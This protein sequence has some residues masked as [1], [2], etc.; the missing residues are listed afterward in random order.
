MEASEMGKNSKMTPDSAPHPWFCTT[1]S[2]KALAYALSL[3][4]I[5]ETVIFWCTKSLIQPF[6]SK[7]RYESRN[8][9]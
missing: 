4:D 5:G 9:Y 1:F 6:V 3:D 8:G 2:G 7:E